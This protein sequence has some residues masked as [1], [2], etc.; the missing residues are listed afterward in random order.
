M[1]S[2]DHHGIS[3]F[4]EVLEGILERVDNHLYILFAEVVEVGVVEVHS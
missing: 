1:G 3:L 2:S 4:A